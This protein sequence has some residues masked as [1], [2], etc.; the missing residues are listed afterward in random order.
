MSK[1][2]TIGFTE[3]TAEEFFTLLLNAGVTKLID[4]RISPGSQL[5]GFAKKADLPYF[6]KTIGNI[7][8]THEPLF[9]PT[10]ELLHSYREKEVTWEEYEKIYTELIAGRSVENILDAGELG[11]ACLLCSEHLPDFC[12]RRL[13]ADYLKKQYR[14]LE[15][16]HLY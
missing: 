6:L 2:F 3:K 1:L 12:H 13:L 15:I 11:N 8:Y 5:A 10:K 7:R 9:A 14:N 4:T 16:V